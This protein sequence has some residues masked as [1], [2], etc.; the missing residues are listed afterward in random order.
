[1]TIFPKLSPKPRIS[2]Q[3]TLNLKAVSAKNL[4]PTPYKKM[5]TEKQSKTIG[6]CKGQM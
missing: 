4:T 6:K 1:M 3:L 2:C 5:L